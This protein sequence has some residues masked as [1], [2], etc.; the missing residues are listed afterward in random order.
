MTGVGILYFDD[1]SGRTLEQK[2][3]Q[4]AGTFEKKMQSAPRVCYVN[5][6]DWNREIEILGILVQPLKT[7]HPNCMWLCEAEVK[8]AQKAPSALPEESAERTIV[9]E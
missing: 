4:A 5:P 2:I 8:K 1:T 6:N 7:I 3:I 9:T